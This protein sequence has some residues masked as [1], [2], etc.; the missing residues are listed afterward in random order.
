MISYVGLSAVAW[1][2]ISTLMLL[3]IVVMM[4]MRVI[5]AVAVIIIA[6]CGVVV[7]A[8]IVSLKHVLKPHHTKE[9]VEKEECA[10][11]RQ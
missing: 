4:M 1:L 8:A 7:V 6:G 9:Q 10:E 2:T 11:L 5:V 3:S